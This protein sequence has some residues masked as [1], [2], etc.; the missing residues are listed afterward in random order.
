MASNSPSYGFWNLQDVLG[1]RV[2]DV[3]I[4]TISEAIKLG[5]AEYNRVVAE[6]LSSL[7]EVTEKYKFRYRLPGDG[8]LAPLTD[9]GTILPVKPG[10]SQDIELPIE[11]AGTAFSLTEEAM[12][13]KTVGDLQDMYLDAQRRDSDWMFRHILSSLFYAAGNWTYTDAQYGSLTVKPLANNDGE[14]YVK[15]DGTLATAAVQHLAEA[16]AIANAANPFPAMRTAL[17]AY[18]HN[19][20]RVVCYVPTALRDDVEALAVFVAANDANL[21]KGSGSDTLNL[22]PPKG[23]GTEV[24]GYVKGANFWMVE[25]PRLPSAYM[26]AHCPDSPFKPIAMRQY[27]DAALQGLVQ[28]MHVTE[29]GTKFTFKRHAGFGALNRVG[30]VVQYIG[31]DTYAAPAGYTAVPLAI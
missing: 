23:L 24:F 22:T 29:S 31:S 26:F 13:A 9:E 14:D 7:V 12:S 18:P 21:T 4:E 17:M 15:N 25:A 20:G 2:T 19:T 10:N 1:R 16:D 8:T 30:A 5:A 6:S 28:R 11:S 27:P 3:G